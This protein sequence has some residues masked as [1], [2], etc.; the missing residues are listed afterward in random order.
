MA[1]LLKKKPKLILNRR[2]L[3]IIKSTLES[4]AMQELRNELTVC[5]NVSD[6]YGAKPSPFPV[7]AENSERIFLPRHYGIKNFNRYLDAVDIK[8]SKG[9]MLNKEVEFKG[10][11]RDN[12]HEPVKIS[13]ENLNK[14][15]LEG[16]GGGILALPCGYGKTSISL[17]LACALGRKTLVIV[18]KEFLLN[19]WVER[20][21]QFCPGAKIGRLQQ[22]RVEIEGNDIVI[23]M[24]QSIAMK[25]YS[26]DIFNEFGTLIIDECH[27]ISSRV[28]S[29]ALKKV[30]CWYMIGLS[31]TPNRKDGLTKVLKWYIGDIMF[32]AKR[33]H[34]VIPLV[35]RYFIR[36]REPVYSKELLN[37]K[38]KP[39]SSVM[40]T[41]ICDYL[42][43]TNWM[44][45]IIKNEFIPIEKRQVLVLAHRRKHLEDWADKLPKDSW[46]YYLGGMK[47]KDLD[48][49]SK[50]KVILATY[51]MADKGLDIPTLNTL[52]LASPKSD[53]VQA[54]GRVMR[55]DKIDDENERPIIMDFIDTFSM[56]DNQSKKRLKEYN[57]EKYKI[58]NYNLNDDGTIKE[59]GSK[60]KPT[61]ESETESETESD[62]DELET[63]DDKEA[64]KMVSEFDY[65]TPVI[66]ISKKKKKKIID[67][68]PFSDDE[69]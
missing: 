43:R 47:Q 48:E 33:K 10:K 44:V 53:I 26:R 25:D 11:L 36:A 66:K 24:L 2:G 5:P 7:Y 18:D 39:N 63:D 17:Y 1:S 19:Q 6:D 32:K 62:I 51:H 65:L 69:L 57:K 22:N 14:P 42:P 34:K 55:K 29:R 64:R 13:L 28:Y 4:D 16:G 37:W 12:Q 67:E 68:F 49:S 58:I 35:R 46:G 9:K 21:E 3:S 59:F 41:Q 45:N 61:I 60:S 27:C 52:V 30:Q 23:G 50:K 15:I 56:F 38:G 54:V 40:L 8:I 20:I 31:A